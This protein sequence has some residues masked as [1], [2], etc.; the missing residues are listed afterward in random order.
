M[1]HFIA[2]T[3]RSITPVSSV[4]VNEEYYNAI[5]TD[6]RKDFIVTDGSEAGL[7]TI[8]KYRRVCISELGHEAVSLEEFTGFRSKRKKLIDEI[9]L[10]LTHLR[11]RATKLEEEL[12][13][14]I[15]QYNSK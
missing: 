13:V 7:A 8:T 10:A 12:A 4:E 1:P 6:S 3:T 14:L 9:E 5:R 2:F 11:K 15:E